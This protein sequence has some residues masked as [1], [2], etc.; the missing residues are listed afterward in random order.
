MVIQPRLSLTL[1]ALSG[2]PSITSTPTMLATLPLISK[3]LSNHMTACLSHWIFGQDRLLA[4][5]L[6]LSSILPF[7]N[8]NLLPHP[9]LAAIWSPAVSSTRK[10]SDTHTV[11]RCGSQSHIEIKDLGQMLM[12]ILYDYMNYLRLTE[13]AQ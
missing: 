3:S 1:A 9:K 7:P 11:Q 12:F 6:F 10:P 13:S 2:A 5:D 4:V 8:M